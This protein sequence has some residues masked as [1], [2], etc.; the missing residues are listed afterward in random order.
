VSLFD[1]QQNFIGMAAG[2]RGAWI[3]GKFFDFEEFPVSLTNKRTA[4]RKNL[5]DTM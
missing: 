3:A 1:S 2:R 5:W 4:R